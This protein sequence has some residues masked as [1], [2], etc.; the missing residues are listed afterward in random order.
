MAV[1][2]G[3]SAIER[4]WRAEGEGF[5]WLLLATPRHQDGADTAFERFQASVISSNDNATGRGDDNEVF[6]EG[7]APT[8]AGFAVLMSRASD[9]A[10]LRRFVEDLAVVL[11]AN[12]LTG[13]LTAAG[14][15]T[16]PTWAQGGPVLAAFFAWVPDLDSMAREKQTT[17][18]WHVPADRT[19]RVARLAVTW[20]GPLTSRSIVRVGQH[21]VE[22]TGAPT[23]TTV[24]T[25]LARGVAATGMAGVELVDEPARIVR[26]ADLAPGGE[27]VL[28]TAPGAGNEPPW[29]DVVGPL[30]DA[31]TALPADLNQGF[32]RPTVRRALSAQMLDA[33]LKLP[34]IREHH[35]RYN[36]HLLDRFIPDVHGIQVLRD[37]HLADLTDTRGWRITDLTAG[38]HL[39]E[40]KDLEPWYA[41]TLPDP[42]VL[43]AAR[44]QFAS[45]LLTPT[46]IKSHPAPRWA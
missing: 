18:G 41:S 10:A 28:Q 13:S 27:M 33:T 23:T 31:L 12:G 22:L 3:W 7:P 46:L 4:A 1:Q 45:I 20:A 35:V 32:I 6:A 14:D 30:R 21:C 34:G 43:E 19:D 24:A 2:I 26:Q 8:A 42:A 17:M 40:A 44:A 9:R 36:K 11:E 29:R 25:L 16:A 5:T 37:E 38:R 39:V 15:A